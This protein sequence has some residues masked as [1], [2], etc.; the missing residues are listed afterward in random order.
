MKRARSGRVSKTPVAKKKR[1]IRG[2]YQLGR[3]LARPPMEVHAFDIA[4]TQSTFAV[5]GSF[6][7]LNAMTNGAE[8]YQRIGRKVYMKSIHLRGWTVNN[9]TVLADY[10][11]LLVVYDAQPNAALP[12]LAAV[13]QD[14]NAGAATSVVSEINLTNRARFKIL[15]DHPIMFPP[16]TFTA[17][18]LTNGPNYMETDKGRFN[19][20]MFIKLR[21][22]E[23]EYNA[24]NGGT[25]ADIT[26]GS[27]FLLL[28]D[29]IGGVWNFNWSSRLRYYY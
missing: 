2:D 5:A 7:V 11:R 6:T 18:V 8:L 9:G 4:N 13:L 17:G 27:I 21:G 22:L 3:E 12:A 23:A 28:V 16:V 10:A 29:A 20:D 1:V 24:V 14:S 15:R 19:I 25:V 26:S